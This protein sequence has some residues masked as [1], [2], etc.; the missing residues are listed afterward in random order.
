MNLG[1]DFPELAE[2]KM[3]VYALDNYFTALKLRRK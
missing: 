1:T 2:I 3:D